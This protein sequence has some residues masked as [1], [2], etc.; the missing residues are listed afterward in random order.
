[1]AEP[2]S[3]E[4]LE[5]IV[6]ANDT[7]AGLLWGDARVLLDE[8]ARL[9]AALKHAERER[10]LTGWKDAREQAAQVVL[11]YRTHHGDQYGG[12]KGESLDAL[13]IA[14]Q[15]RRMQP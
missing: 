14:Q 15:I 10:Y 1:V 6:R 3:A 13:P 12:Y 5:Q 4:R 7:G 9:R 11:A 8:V 2:M